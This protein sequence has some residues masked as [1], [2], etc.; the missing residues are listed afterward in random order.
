MMLCCIVY[1]GFNI[2]VVV[3]LK[4]NHN[5]C[6]TQLISPLCTLI[7]R[8]SALRATITQNETSNFEPILHCSKNINDFEIYTISNAAEDE[9]CWTVNEIR[10]PFDLSSQLF[11]FSIL[12]TAMNKMK[13]CLAFHHVIADGSSIHTLTSEL[14]TLLSVGGKVAPNPPQLTSSLSPFTKRTSTTTVCDGTTKKI[15]TKNERIQQKWIALVGSAKHCTKLDRRYSTEHTQSEWLAFKCAPNVTEAVSYVSKCFNVS[16]TVVMASVY[17]LALQA[18]LKSTESLVFGCAFLNRRRSQQTMVGHTVGVLP[19]RVDFT[20]SSDLAGILAQVNEGWYLVM[21]GGTSLVDLHSIL[22]CLQSSPTSSSTSPLQILFSFL[23]TPKNP[24][25]K[26]IHL[27]GGKEVECG[28]EYLRSCDAHVDLF[29]EVRSPQSWSGIGSESSYLFTWEYRNCCLSRDDV[30]QLHNL[31]IGFLQSICR[32]SSSVQRIVHCSDSFLSPP[33]TDES[34][35]N[36]TLDV[37]SEIVGNSY[38]FTNRHLNLKSVIKNNENSY[39]P[40]LEVWSNVTSCDPTLATPIELPT[41]VRPPKHTSIVEGMLLQEPRTESFIEQFVLKA[42]DIPDKRAFLYGIETFTYREAAVMMEKIASVLINEGVN[43][44]HHVGIILPHT[45]LLYISLLATLR[46]GAG[47]VPLALH[48]PEDRILDMLKLSDSKIIISDTNTLQNKLPNYKGRIVCID[49]DYMKR[50]LSSVD[51]VPQLP[52]IVYDGNQIAYII[53]TSGTTGTPKGVAITNYSL[54]YL[55]SNFLLLVTPYD[56]EVTLAGCTVAWDGHVL[57]SLGPLLNGACLVVMPALDIQEGITHALMSPS[58]ASVVTFPKS[59]RSLMVGGEAFTQT[60]FDNIKTIPKK[61]ALY[62]P[63]EATVFVAGD[64]IIGSDATPYISNLGRAMP[65]TTLMVCDDNQEPVALGTEGEL[66]IAGPLV[67]KIGYYKNTEKTEAA[68][69]TSPL[70]QYNVVYRTGDW[71]RM[72][73]DC[74]IMYLGR[75]D[76]QVKLRGMRFQLLEVENKLR[77]HPQVKMAVVVVRNQGTPSAQLIGFVTPRSVDVNSLFEFARSNLPSYMVPSVITILDEMPLRK[78]GKVDRIALLNLKQPPSTNAI[79]TIDADIND[80]SIQSLTQRADKL[81]IIFGRVLNQKSYSTTA[82]FFKNGGQSLLLF[83]LLQ[84][85]NFEMKCNLPLSH[86]LQYST[87]LALAKAL[88]SD[89][90]HEEIHTETSNTTNPTHVTLEDTVTTAMAATNAPTIINDLT[91]NDFDYLAPVPDIQLSNIDSTIIDG[92]VSPQIDVITLSRKL[93][94]E[95]GFYIPPS[96]LKRYTDF[97]TLQTHLKLKSI[98]KYFKDTRT[99]I[100]R[101]PLSSPHSPND[102]PLIFLHAGIIGWALPYIKLAKSLNQSSII[103]Q[104]CE[105]APTTSFESM[106]SYYVDAILEAQPEGPYSLVGVCYGAMLVYEVARQLTDRG[107]KI[108]LAVFLNHSPA[109]EKL[110]ALFENDGGPL[111]NTFVDPIVF[112]HKILGLPLDMMQGVCHG[113]GVVVS[114][115]ENKQM[116]GDEKL[117]RNVKTIVKQILSSPDS[118]WIPFT[119]AELESVY[120]GFFKRLRCAWRN[121]KPRPGADIRHYVLIR[122]RSNPLFDSYDYNLSSLLQAGESSFPRSVTVK[123][124]PKSKMGMLSD[125]ETF[126]FVKENIETY[127]SRP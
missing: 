47:Y 70:P 4:T 42:N 34:P 31:T 5:L 120:L 73:P 35:T 110:P 63:T 86:L 72:L 71:T 103:I 127:L 29:L 124:T 111:S 23:P 100:I 58:A 32:E 104:R 1:R 105:A 18:F 59:M 16:P 27:F 40:G 55:L 65:N 75:T 17:S 80:S 78:E 52:D 91:L 85:V 39:L 26:S 30:T 3:Q 98:L 7:E 25:P 46:C 28:V 117:E 119:S 21:E 57:D 2:G 51:Y 74:R 114:G 12:Q 125:P 84:M 79:D 99:P 15:E 43:P 109:I 67:S 54:S 77:Q 44:G 113:C 68:F 14:L 90:T 9:E 87:P 61:L 122:D 81:A 60:C 11:R 115:D 36:G 92:G 53:F 123:Q 88:T 76:D 93:Q 94:E 95:T 121:Y 20:K 89:P 48:N 64:Y 24:L 96:S 69:V 56:T 19:M 8:H 49:S 66:C 118:A 37:D 112:F 22:P 102:R 13:L 97:K 106:A 101:L 45:H 126:Q 33:I 10:K 6:Y 108:R 50:I 82:D 107:K 83:R 41:L 62:G 38:H 116:S